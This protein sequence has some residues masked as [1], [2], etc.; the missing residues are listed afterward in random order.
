MLFFVVPSLCTELFFLLMRTTWLLLRFIVDFVCLL[1]NFTSSFSVKE[2]WC[3]FCAW[4]GSDFKFIFFVC[5]LIF[6]F[7]NYFIMRSLA[8]LNLKLLVRLFLTCQQLGYHS[9]HNVMQFLIWPKRVFLK[10]GCWV[11]IMSSLL[12]GTSKLGLF[13]EFVSRVRFYAIFNTFNSPNKLVVF[14]WVARKLMDLKLAKLILQVNL[15]RTVSNIS[16]SKII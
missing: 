9:F 15:L 4:N 11:R 3:V 10:I 8:L 2:I 7:A 6:D 16:F 5:K 12:P 1:E 14:R 13:L